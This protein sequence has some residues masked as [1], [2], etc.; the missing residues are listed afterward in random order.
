M[1]QCLVLEIGLPY[2]NFKDI[3]DYII[4]VCYFLKLLKVSKTEIR[5]FVREF[6]KITAEYQASVDSSV[7]SMV[8][9]ANLSPRLSILKKYI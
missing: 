2:V 7:A 8:V 9:H 3:G 4:L 6:E 1:K 5:A